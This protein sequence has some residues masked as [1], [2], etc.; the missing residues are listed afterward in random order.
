MGNLV[1]LAEF[2]KT[3]KGFSHYHKHGFSMLYDAFF[4]G[5]KDLSFNLLELGIL[6][7]S[8]LRMW[9]DYFKNAK[10]YG[11]D[12]NPSSMISEE[13]IFTLCGDQANSAV[14]SDVLSQMD[15][16]PELIID[17]GCHFQREQQVSLEYLFPKLKSGGWYVIEDLHSSYHLG[18]SD[19]YSTS[20]LKLLRCLRDGKDFESDWVSKD[21]YNH[22]RESTQE[23][24]IFEKPS[25][26]F[27]DLVSRGERVLVPGAERFNCNNSIV[28]FIKK[29]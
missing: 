24:Y 4:R 15:S 8:S 27:E 29:R 20:T 7:G 17:D 22:L 10:I 9:R 1:E 3:D 23:V 5:R 28:S 13:R 19:D 2:H 16:L 11:L 14:L 12:I 18:W 21:F 6:D 26:V 25:S